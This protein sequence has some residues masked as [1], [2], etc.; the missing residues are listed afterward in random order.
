MILSVSGY[1]RLNQSLLALA[2]EL[3]DG[4]LVMVLEGGYN[5]DALGACVVAGLRQLLGRAPGPDPIGEVDAPEP[6][7]E[8]ERV[9]ATLRNHHPLLAL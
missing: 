7:P 3:C 8:I 6:L 2:D 4:R 1:A 5:L 9:I